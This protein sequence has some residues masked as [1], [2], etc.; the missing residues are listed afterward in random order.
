MLKLWKVINMHDV[1][2]QSTEAWDIVV[3]EKGVA[4]DLHYI[5]IGYQVSLMSQSIQ[6]YHFQKL[7]L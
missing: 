7:C 2:F 4:F 5:G 3:L 6:N 1:V